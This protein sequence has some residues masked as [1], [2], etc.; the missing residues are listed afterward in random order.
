MKNKLLKIR[1]IIVL[2]LFFLSAMALDSKSIIPL[3]V[4]CLT[5]IWLFLFTI[6]NTRG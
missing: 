6:A 5:T 2:G 3:I 1:A 4:F